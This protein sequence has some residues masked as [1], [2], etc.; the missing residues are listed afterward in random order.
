VEK[1]SYAE[2]VSEEQQIVVTDKDGTSTPGRAI[3]TRALVTD[4]VNQVWALEIPGNGDSVLQFRRKIFSF[5][6]PDAFIKVT[7]LTTHDEQGA[8]AVGE[9]AARRGPGRSDRGPD[10]GARE[11]GGA[12]RPIG[13]NEAL[14]P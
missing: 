4:G 1:T 12:G 6:T 2:G 13:E 7:T 3:S 14:A 8:S 10:P 11:G 9:S 5:G